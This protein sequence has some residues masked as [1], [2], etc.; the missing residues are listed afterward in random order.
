MKYRLQNYTTHQFTYLI[1]YLY[2]GKIKNLKIN[3]I[4]QVRQKK[5]TKQV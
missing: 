4:Q 5:C 2:Q 1:Y 3:E